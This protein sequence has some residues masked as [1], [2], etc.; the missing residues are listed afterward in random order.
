MSDN[1][2]VAWAVAAPDHEYVSLFRESAEAAASQE[3]ATVT[4]LYCQPTLTETQIYWLSYAAKKLHDPHSKSCSS[5][6]CSMAIIDIL[7]SL[8]RWSNAGFVK[9][10]KTK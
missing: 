5:S 4:P 6:Q 8:G 1:E 10:K 7:R 2:P 9:R 3:G